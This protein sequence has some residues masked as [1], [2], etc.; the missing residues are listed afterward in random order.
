VIVD[1]LSKYA[2]LF[3]IPTKYG[4]S[5]VAYIFFREVFKLHGILRNIVSDQ[6]SRFLS[7]FWQELFRL[8]EIELTPST[9]C[10]P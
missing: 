2:Q 10:H 3:S 4:A 5:Q 1:T 6:D 9:S 7:A 8:S